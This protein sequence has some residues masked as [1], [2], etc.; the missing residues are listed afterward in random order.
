MFCQLETES[1]NKTMLNI[2][3]TFALN[4]GRGSHNIG[5]IV[6]TF[7]MCLSLSQH[8]SHGLE[9]EIYIRHFFSF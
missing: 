5:L 7:V 6:Y 4:R 2:F 1:A 8:S 9:K 3:V